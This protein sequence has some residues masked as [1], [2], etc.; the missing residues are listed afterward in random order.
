LEMESTVTARDAE[1]SAI[2]VRY[3]AVLP[4]IAGRMVALEE[5][6]E[7]YYTANRVLIEQ[8]GK[9][10]VQLG[11][12]L[13]GMRAPA[14]AALVPMAGWTWERVTKK[15]KSLFKAR[16]FHKPKPP[17]PDKVKIKRELTVA[18]M[19]KCGITLDTTESFYV[20]LNRLDRAA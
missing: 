20:E 1:V 5:N 6:L 9:K 7:K 2:L 15:L 3:G 4:A 18:E 11:N 19:A 16:F 13:I 14:N 17:A 8:D 10:S 12:G